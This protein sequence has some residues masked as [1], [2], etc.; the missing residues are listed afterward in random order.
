M[1]NG[2]VCTLLASNIDLA[3]SEFK[4]VTKTTECGTRIILSV[5]YIHENYK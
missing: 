1:E 4:S 2:P 5:S 3:Y